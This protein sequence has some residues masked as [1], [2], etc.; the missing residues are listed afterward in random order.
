M[1]DGEPECE[2][3]V[4]PVTSCLSDRIDIRDVSW[5]CRAEGRA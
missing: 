4:C 3:C 5:L 1:T 2:I